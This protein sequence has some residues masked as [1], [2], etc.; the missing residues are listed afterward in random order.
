M[1]SELRY[2]GKG[3][4]V[5]AMEGGGGFFFSNMFLILREG[6]RFLWEQIER[7]GG[8]DSLR[9]GFSLVNNFDLTMR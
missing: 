1:G 3:W 7:Y 5:G 2:A 4:A 6:W 9:K 8:V